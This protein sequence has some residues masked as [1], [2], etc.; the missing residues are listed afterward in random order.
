M[1]ELLLLGPSGAC[2]LSP[3]GLRP[4][5]DS[6][7]RI[8]STGFLASR[9]L[10]LDNLQVMSMWMSTPEEVCF[11]TLLKLSK[12]PI[13]FPSLSGSMEVCL[14]FFLSFFFFFNF[15]IHCFIDLLEFRITFGGKRCFEVK[16]YTF[17]YIQ[18]PCLF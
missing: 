18:I 10:V 2:F 1:G 9:R 12:T 5:T 16:E 15:Y 6:R 13:S 7:P 14:S 17:S 11:T 8:S 3:S 4:P